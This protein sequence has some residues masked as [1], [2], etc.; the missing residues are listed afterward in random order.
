MIEHSLLP[1]IALALVTGVLMWIGVKRSARRILQQQFTTDID[2]GGP[3]VECEIR[4]VADEASTPC[5]VRLTPAGWYMCR[6]PSAV[7]RRY[8]ISGV[9]YLKRP[10]LIPW[11]LLEYHYGRFPLR[12]WLRFDVPSAKA[13]FFIRQRVAM[14]LLRD[15]GRPLPSAGV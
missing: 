12:G 6:P 14:D 2:P 10:V 13:T 8:S 9:P 5:G 7:A 15:A 3:L 4:F 11:T 1:A